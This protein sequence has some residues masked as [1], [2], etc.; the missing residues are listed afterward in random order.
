[1][2][3][4]GRLALLAFLLTQS[5]AYL[6]DLPKVTFFEKVNP[7][8]LLG[9]GFAYPTEAAEGWQFKV[10]AVDYQEKVFALRD[11]KSDRDSIHVLIDCR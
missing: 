9:K 4:I 7:T 3:T 1:M 5:T 6:Q 2:N 8:H 10:R 11:D